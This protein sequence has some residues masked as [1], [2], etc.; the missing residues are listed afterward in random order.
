MTSP[1]QTATDHQMVPDPQSPAPAGAWHPGAAA[2]SSA[3]A[4][5]GVADRAEAEK[6]LA[7]AVPGAEPASVPAST[8]AR[9]T[10][11]PS[12]RWPKIWAVFVDDPRSSVELA[13]GLVHDSVQALVASVTEPLDSLLSAWAERKR[14]NQGTAHGGPAQ[15]RVPEPSRRFFSL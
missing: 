10:T 8:V 14:R 11:S 7:S 15:P 4:E 12:T 9:D 2:V 1:R 5:A 3:A 6:P 13:A